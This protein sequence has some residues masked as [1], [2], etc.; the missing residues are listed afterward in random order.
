MAVNLS[1]VGGV[2]AQFFTN[3]GAVLTGGK[4]YTY[5]AGT[6][7]PATTF[8]SS[9]GSTPW[10]NP[11]VLDAAGRVP[12]GGEI[13][14][15]DGVIYKFVLKDSNDV[16]IATYDNITGINSNFVNYTAS[17]EIQTATAGQTVFNLNT[18]EYSPGTNSLTVYVDGVNQYG[19]GAQYAYLETDSNT[20]TFA[21]GLH[22]GASVKFTTTTQTSG[23]A[24]DA[25]V[26]TYDPPFTGSVPTVVCK[27]LAQ[28]Q[29][30][31]VFDFMTAAQIADVQNNTASIDVTTALQ[32]AIDAISLTGGI[33]YFPAGTY[34]TTDTL[35]MQN[36]ANVRRSGIHFIGQ[37]RQST[38]IKPTLTNKPAIKIRGV[39]LVGPVN[40][41]FYWGGELR[42]MTIDG[43][44]S[45]GTT[46]AIDLLGVYYFTIENVYILKW[47]HGIIQRNDLVVD[48]NPDFTSTTITIRN[49]WI[50]YC[51][52]FGIYQTGGIS[53]FGWLIDSTSVGLC[54][55]GGILIVGGGTVVTRTSISLCGFSAENTLVSASAIGLQVGMT[56]GTLNNIEVS[57]CEFDSNTGK[58]ISLD[59]WQGADIHDNRFIHNDRYSIGQLT[60]S[61]GL[62]I[63]TNGLGSVVKG[64]NFARNFFRIDTAGTMYGVAWNSVSNVTDIR[65]HST[66]FS[67]QTGGAAVIN[68]YYGYT[69]SN[70]H[71]RQNY[72]IDD[73][74]TADSAS[75]GMIYVGGIPSAEYLG[76]CSSSTVPSSAVIVYGTQE[77]VNSS[78][79]GSTLYNTTTGVFTCPV[80]AYYEVF[81]TL[82]VAG[83]T[84]SEYYQIQVR[85]NTSAAQEFDFAGN[86]L[87][88]TT[89]S[90]RYRF[91]A[92]AGDTIDLYS[93]GANGKTITSAYSQLLIKLIDA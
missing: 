1:P 72:I 39:P 89:F 20:V 63:A 34:K 58:H 57:F 25:C 21:S 70:M 47:R 71:L 44:N 13:W 15:T 36:N 33:L 14:L 6:T 76:S 35:V 68:R 90:G 67:D 62:A 4:L 2:A 48:P 43:S 28:F 59:N 74:F 16:L 42:D 50:F 40:T 84:T 69:A 23:N 41:T 18:M 30:L 75:A 60:P 38:I 91:F 83:A 32:S 37:G 80:T 78:I 17:Q 92:N 56:S 49:V 29:N 82:A 55:L 22:V 73:R 54:G 77:S 66:T 24:T 11:I 51:Q 10:T 64:V 85:Q 79:F 86:G 9:N 87:S 5:A 31:N 19:P 81:F 52:G 93:S 46:D 12:S 88:R 45:T 7:T 8:T 61:Q 65:C 3:T 27:K 53:P 26:V